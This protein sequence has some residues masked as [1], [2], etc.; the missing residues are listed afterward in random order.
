MACW[1]N[2]PEIPSLRRV[3]RELSCHLGAAGIACKHR[4]GEDD[5]VPPGLL[6]PRDLALG[7]WH[8]C[9]LH[10]GGLRC[11]GKDN[12][13][14]QQNVPDEKL[15]FGPLL[16]S[17]ADAPLFL[18]TLADFV[19]SFDAEFLETV[20]GLADGQE[21]SRQLFLLNALR[22]FFV[23]SGYHQTRDT[24]LLA[25]VREIDR[26]TAPSP[27]TGGARV[28][29][30]LGAG[31]PARKFA[32]QILA[33]SLRSSRALVDLAQRQK[34]ETSIA[35][36]GTGVAGGPGLSAAD[37]TVLEGVQR[38]LAL[39]TYLSARVLMNQILMTYLKGD[40]P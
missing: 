30:S 26:W 36:L 4:S 28:L 18:R 29:S 27:S 14:G 9:A 10:D 13:E 19:Y 23:E 11:W 1:S 5:W 12:S 33:A 3:S 31:W 17:V 7:D 15:R 35:R 40:G 32:M 38:E 2:H 22:P 20:W 6:R 16:R 39:N 25:A 21:E 34:I 37:F 8:L 24:Y